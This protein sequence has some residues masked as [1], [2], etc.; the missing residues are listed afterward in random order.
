MIDELITLRHSLHCFFSIVNLF[1]ANEVIKIMDLFSRLFTVFVIAADLMALVYFGGHF[2]IT[3]HVF[4][5]H[6]TQ[7]QERIAMLVPIEAQ[8]AD[9]SVKAKKKEIPLMPASAE[10][11]QKVAG[12]CLSCHTFNKNGKSMTGPALW[13][14]VGQP[15]ARAD[16]YQYSQVF[17]GMQ[18]QS[19]VWSEENLDKFLAS[20]RKFAKGTKMSFSGIRKQQQRVDLIEYLKT[21]K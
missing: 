6:S 14:T 19:M 20:P 18:E 12:L 16:G 17:L 7:Q 13:N 1:S 10:R 21:L 2:I 8:A 5:E 4:P 11:G 15:I 3:G 9:T